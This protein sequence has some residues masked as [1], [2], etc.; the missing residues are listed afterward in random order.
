[1]D[2]YGYFVKGGHT[3]QQQNSSDELLPAVAP[4]VG[5]LMAVPLVVVCRFG[6]VVECNWD[7]LSEI[8]KNERGRGSNQKW[9][10]L[11]RMA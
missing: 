11:T 5:G 2:R 10:C 6:Q 7:R 8:E 4:V 3:N 1:M 9:M